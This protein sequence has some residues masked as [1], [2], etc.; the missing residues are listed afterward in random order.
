MSTVFLKILNMSIAATWLIAVVLLVRLLLKKAPKWISC[1]L[2]ALVALRLV[3][4]FSFQSPLSLLP[5]GETI[6]YKS[7]SNEDEHIDPAKPAE[8]AAA[9]VT[10]SGAKTAEVRMPVIDSGVKVIDN[11]LNPVIERAYRSENRKQTPAA[12]S[13]PSG[14]AVPADPLVSNIAPAPA[15]EKADPLRTWTLIAA[16]VWIAGTAGLLIYALIS[17]LS[18]RKKVS[19]SIHVRDNIWAADGIKT[20]FILGIFKPVIYVPSSLQGEALDYVLAHEEAHLQRRDHLWKPLGYLLLAIYWFNPLCWVAYIL[21]C[22]DIES[23]C[24]EKAVKFM[25]HEEMAEYSQT[26]LNLSVQSHQIAACPVAFGEVNVK[27][28]IRSILN[29]KKPAF[30]MVLVALLACIA[31]AGCFLTDPKKE[32]DPGSSEAQTTEAP[33]DPTKEPTKEPTS[34][35]T[36]APTTEPATEAPTTEAPSETPDETISEEPRAVALENAQIL[37]KIPVN[38]GEDSLK[39]LIVH[40]DYTPDYDPSSEKCYELGPNSFALLNEEDVFILDSCNM[41]I[42]RFRKDAVPEFFPIGQDQ[43][44]MYLYEPILLHEDYV[45]VIGTKGVLR[46][47]YVTRESRFYK[48]NFTLGGK[49]AVQDLIWQDGLVVCNGNGANLKLD[50][51]TGTFS[52]TQDGYSA[53]YTSN[54]INVTSAGKNYT[55]PVS[56]GFDTVD[57]VI[58]QGPENSFFVVSAVG[59]QVPTETESGI[60]MHIGYDYYLRQYGPKT[61]EKVQTEEWISM[62][63]P[64][65]SIWW[66]P[67]KLAF[68]GTDGVYA[69][70][71][72]KDYAYVVKYIDFVY[73]DEQAEET[74]TESEFFTLLKKGSLSDDMFSWFF[75][76][77]YNGEKVQIVP[78]RSNP[79][80][81][82]GGLY[83]MN[84]VNFQG[85]VYYRAEEGQSFEE[86]IYEMEDAICGIFT[87]EENRE[88]VGYVMTDY[89][90]Y[91]LNEWPFPEVNMPED[92][93]RSAG[94]DVW[95]IRFL[96]IF[97]KYDGKDFGMTFEE[98]KAESKADEYG[99]ISCFA[100][101]S[102]DVFQMVLVKQ[103][104][105]YLLAKPTYLTRHPEGEIYAPGAAPVEYKHKA[106]DSAKIALNFDEVLAKGEALDENAMKGIEA[107]FQKDSSPYPWYFIRQSFND[108]SEIDA[109]LLFENG[110]DNEV[111]QEEQNAAWE[112]SGAYG[113]GPQKR[114]IQSAREIFRKYTGT[115]LTDDQI[116]AFSEWLYLPEYDAY[117]GFR[118]DATD[119]LRTHTLGR[120]VRLSAAKA[121]E[122][123]LPVTADG[124]IAVE[125][126]GSTGAGPRGPQRYGMVLLIPD[127]DSYKIAA[128][129]VFEK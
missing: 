109:Y 64:G 120:G 115:D 43:I 111:S 3:I 76:N 110:I 35:A 66:H 84:P 123:G 107:F 62:M 54:G 92:N 32:T 126:T 42:M 53:T 112:A 15:A 125:W 82:F 41:R 106:V 128:N 5:S 87:Q 78:N 121:A 72:E 116:N 68:I 16:I 44:G 4:P 25:G 46:W 37:F 75:R 70:L 51:E 23:A 60:E 100:Q 10:D 117:Y 14:E 31:V 8:N 24:D 17:Y 96:Y 67:H 114:T 77:E 124:M 93:L 38:Q 2:W 56:K 99:L 27:Q 71:L 57:T 118:T 90:I 13:A 119:D 95:N 61:P 34:E 9:P 103:G 89:H 47:N 1:V 105:V 63:L 101:G 39:G 22:R 85:A 18:L 50:E 49:V 65:E 113:F 86:V 94:E 91:P 74:L 80:D 59:K 7:V 28:R 29:Y 12:Q 104:D 6:T 55:I 81:A 21:L 26:L 48:R 52:E 97:Y 69:M 98:Q 102:D 19:A 20:P 58:G 79:A 129:L 122:L 33:T 73:E 40:D 127:G 108:P 83:G 88:R 45:Y 36:Q 11:A 30:C